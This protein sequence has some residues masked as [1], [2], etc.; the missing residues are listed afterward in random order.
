MRTRNVTL[1]LLLVATVLAQQDTGMITGQ[2]TDPSG[3][4]VPSATII[5]VNVATNVLTKVVTSN[6]GLFV[7]TPIRIGIY[8]IAVE[9]SG[10]KKTVRDGIS[11]R[12]QDRLRVDFRLELGEVSES[13]S[14]TS[15][16]PILQ[17]ETS[18][19]GQ[20]ISTKPVR[21][22]HSTGATSSNS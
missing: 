4:P 11:L 13:V 3:S 17:S 1:F 6:D 12:V 19:L 8:S 20:V 2:V 16:A 9:V 7:A 22:F 15:E 18:S 10:F 5:L 21:S 14:V